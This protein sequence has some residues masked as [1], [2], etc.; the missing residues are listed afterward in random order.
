MHHRPTVNDVIADEDTSYEL[1]IGYAFNRIL[2][3]QGSYHNFG[4]PTGFAGCPPEVL[5]ILAFSPEAV[6]V[7]GWAAAVAA[8][9]PLGQNLDVFGKLGVIAW[10]TSAVSPSLNDSGAD[11]LYG[12]GATWYVSERWG[13]QLAYEEADLDI[14]TGKF[15]LV[16]RF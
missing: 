1:G 4:K 14:R 11:L 13:L 7:D 5:C 16:Y 12:A 10:D 2:S 6:K 15:G 9:W 3:L 8:T